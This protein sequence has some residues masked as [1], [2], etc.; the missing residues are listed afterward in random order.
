MK[1]TARK[2]KP[3]SAEMRDEYRFDYSKSK[4]NRFA[5]KME[6]GT[7]AVVLEPDVAAV[8]KN[9]ESVNKLLR[10]VISAV[11]PKAR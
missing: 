2:K 8:F 7:I 6:S 11:K 4:S 10:S 3:A 1:N 9:A 5:K